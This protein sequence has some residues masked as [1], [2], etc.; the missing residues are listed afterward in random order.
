MITKRE[1]I[2]MFFSTIAAVA[3][4]YLSG[5]GLIIVANVIAK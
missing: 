1:R 2:K 5:L 4:I 3:I